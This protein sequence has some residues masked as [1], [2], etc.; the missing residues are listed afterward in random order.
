MLPHDDRSHRRIGMGC[1]VLAHTM[2]GLFP[3][4]WR[5]LLMVDPLELTSHRVLWSFVLLS[6]LLPILLSLKVWGGWELFLKAVCTRRVLW[7]YAAAALMIAINWLSFVYAVTNG[8]IL[9]ASLG[10]YI[11][12]LLN[13]L[14]G[15]IFL[16]ERLASSQWVAIGLAAIGV[17]VM[18]VAGGGLPW[19]ALG[20]ACSFAIYGLLKKQAPLPALLGLWLE[21][22]I[23]AGPTLILLGM[24]ERTSGTAF[25]AGTLS[26]QALLMFGGVITVAP[27]A[28]FAIASHR[29]SLSTMGVLQYIGPTLQL[30]VGTLIAGET[31]GV[32]RIVG[33]VFVWTGILV[34][35]SRMR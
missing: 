2:W 35:L 18:T 24:M 12:P 7:I 8:R 10:Y 28:L 15:V 25:L 1:A 29:V 3:L 21:T 19:P 4:Y 34:Y 14:L 16:R 13:V 5:N 17:T 9:D 20:M 32:W 26:T 22:A 11:N 27:L 33:F 31:F 30:L 6:V 23:L